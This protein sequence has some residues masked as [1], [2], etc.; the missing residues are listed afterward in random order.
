MKETS[1]L[2][3]LTTIRALADNL[4]EHRMD[5]AEV[6]AL[7]EKGLYELKISPTSVPLNF[8]T[9]PGATLVWRTTR[10]ALHP[11][12]GQLVIA[13]KN[14]FFRDLAKTSPDLLAAGVAAIPALLE[15]IIAQMM[16]DIKSLNEAI[17]TCRKIAEAI[18]EA[19]E[20]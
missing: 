2:E 13:G 12:R 4:L 17:A 11:H 16:A 14:D 1:L 9:V 3:K 8:P 20:S 19:K 15:A 6:I 5:A 10:T 18:T 7:V